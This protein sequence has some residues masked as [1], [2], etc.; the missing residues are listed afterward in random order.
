M[1]SE[2]LSGDSS[3]SGPESLNFEDENLKSSQIP[4]KQKRT[5]RNYMSWTFHDAIQA[6][7]LA[8]QFEERKQTLIEHF[9]TRTTPGRPFCVLSVTIFADLRPLVLVL[10][11]E[12][13]TVS[14]AIIG[15]VQTNPSSPYTLTKWIPSAT[16]EPVS[17]GL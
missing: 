6:D 2:E 8:G 3:D 13:S 9:R 16:W 15:Y 7:V 14:I 5:D 12:N 4:G 11:N 10:P 1:S 17:G